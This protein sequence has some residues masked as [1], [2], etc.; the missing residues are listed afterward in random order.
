MMP[1]KITL[2]LI[3]DEDQQREALTMLFESEGY[4]VLGFPS[5][6]EALLNINRTSP[7]MFITD[8]K[9]TGMDGITFFNEVRKSGLYEHIPFVFISAYNDSAAIDRVKKLG[10]AS[11]ITKPYELDTLLSVVHK[12][13]PNAL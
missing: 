13:L 9:L 1:D 4:N 6:E 8:V 7:H 10:A 11:Y 12:H 5:A 2:F 3:E